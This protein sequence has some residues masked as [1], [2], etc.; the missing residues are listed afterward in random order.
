M[1][2]IIDTSDRSPRGATVWLNRLTWGLRIVL[3][4][5]FAAAAVPKLIGVEG[6]VHL[7]QAIG[8]GQW[9]RYG[10]GL[11]ELAGA[12]LLVAPA[13]GFFGAVIMAA[14]MLGAILTHL[15][16][17]GGSPIPATV[18]FAL[19]GVVAWRLKPQAPAG[20]AG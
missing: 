5:A 13:T 4:L 1:T 16:V 18:L 3:A 12:L 19:S 11:T 20:T 6:M 7:F 14:T 17:I 8:L 15:L 10:T 9:F 2:S